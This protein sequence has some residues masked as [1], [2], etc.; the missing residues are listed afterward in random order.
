MTLRDDVLRTTAVMATSVSDDDHVVVERLIAEGFSQLRA[1]VLLVF[2][3]LGLSRAVIAR[4]PAK[5]PIVLPDTAVIQESPNGKRY[6][7]RLTDVPEFVTALQLGEE[8]FVNGVIPRE[9]FSASCRSVELN[10]VNQALFEEVE[11]GG[12]VISSSILLRLAEAPG[13]EEW[14]RSLAGGNARYL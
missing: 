3:P 10:L 1:E 12:A 6:E 11:I 7:V 9:Q 14:Y 2:V 8:T 4:L 5:P 13:F